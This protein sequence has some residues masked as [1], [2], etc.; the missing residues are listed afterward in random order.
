[1]RSEISH[2]PVAPGSPRPVLDPTKTPARPPSCKPASALSPH[3]QTPP[4]QAC[5]DPRSLPV[6]QRCIPPIAVRFSESLAASPHVSRRLIP[7]TSRPASI[8]ETLRAA[9]H[10]YPPKD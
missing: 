5:C 7:R 9:L 10:L 2:P 3:P 8:H 6:R 4:P 1:M